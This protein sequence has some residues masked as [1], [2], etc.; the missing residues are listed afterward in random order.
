MCWSVMELISRG[1][2]RL[3]YLLGSV[4]GIYTCFVNSEVASC[5]CAAVTQASSLISQCNILAH[6]PICLITM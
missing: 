1:T 4:W 2:C 6:D 3:T 5:Q